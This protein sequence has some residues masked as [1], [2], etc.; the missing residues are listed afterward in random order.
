MD[1]TEKQLS[2]ENIYNGNILHVFKDEIELP[3][4]VHSAR[5]YIKHIGAVC[6]V[7]VTD[8]GKIILERQY[9][10]AVGQTMIEIPAGKLDSADEDPLEAATR[11]LREETGAVA[12]RMEYLGEYYGSPAILSERIHMFLAVG[13][14]FGEQDFDEDELLEVFSMPI[15]DAVSEV[16]AGRITDGKTQAG[17][18]RVAA[19]LGYL[20]K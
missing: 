8:D 18:L 4:G 14:E 15:T 16:L 9:R 13:L 3:N 17:V 19:M 7:P 6:V 5:E 2:S 12:R 20:S 10:Y 1:L 11:E